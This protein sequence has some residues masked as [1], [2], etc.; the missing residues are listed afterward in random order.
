MNFKGKCKTDEQIHD[1]LRKINLAVTVSNDNNF[2]V[3]DSKVDVYQEQ[4]D[5]AYLSFDKSNAVW[6]VV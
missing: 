1:Y 5:I 3:E 2:Q 6:Q 4:K